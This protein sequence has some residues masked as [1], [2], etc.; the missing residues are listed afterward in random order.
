M[1]S[2][3]L[4][5]VRRAPVEGIIAALYTPLDRH[6][7]VQ[8]RALAAHVRFL[9]EA[10][11]HGVLALGS[12][13]EFARLSCEQRAAFLPHVIEAAEGLPVLF[14]ITG[15][16]LDEVV[17]LGRAARRSGVAGVTLMPPYFYPVPQTD[18]AEFF[19][20]AAEAVKLPLYL[21][22]YPELTNT[23]IDLETIEWVADRVPVTG[24]KHSGGELDYLPALVAIGREKSIAIFSGADTQLPEVLGM[25]AV[26]S[27]GGLI[28]FLPE[29]TLRLFN[30]CRKGQ[31]GSVNP[32]AGH[33]HEA[34]RIFARLPFPLSIACG[35][36]ARGFD[37]GV[38]KMVVSAAT[39]R[40][41][42]Q[43]VRDFRRLF[44][45]AGLPLMG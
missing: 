31:A 18:L 27:I 44:K 8:R 4:H 22:N 5:Q 21:Y 36:E 41:Y 7:R 45:A 12:T 16:T 2:K 28:N 30:I 6:D 40:L 35:L 15:T 34:G 38:P 11:L 14:N 43:G 32:A 17:Q 42:R 10:G 9:R 26:G 20:R 3:S 19:L 24:F 33:M 1:K 37:P 13:G 39:E 29:L 23:R 25:G